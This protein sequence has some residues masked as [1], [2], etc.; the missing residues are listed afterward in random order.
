MT[1]SG[2]GISAKVELGNHP[3]FP[4]MMF[5]E[6]GVMWITIATK[7]KPEL[8]FRLLFSLTD[9][10]VILPL[11]F[12]TKKKGALVLYALN[13]VSILISSFQGQFD[14][15][16]L[17]FLLMSIFTFKK[18]RSS[19]FYLWANLAVSIKT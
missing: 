10:L 4:F 2:G 16:P 18:K 12:F 5:I 8:L 14:S 3:Y 15:L 19:I 17:F 13:P 11:Y 9:A 6:A 1:L 7:I